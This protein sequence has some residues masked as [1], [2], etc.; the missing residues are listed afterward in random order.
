[1]KYKV[2]DEVK[3][4]R[5]NDLKQE[6]VS[7]DEDGLLV[8]VSEIDQDPETSSIVYFNTSM[9]EHCGKTYI[10]NNVKETPNKN[11][12]YKLENIHTW[13][14]TETMFER[15]KPEV[16]NTIKPKFKFNKD[17]L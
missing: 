2:G 6:A 13:V 14:F 1:M 16:L 12:L 7:E 11:Y 17:I 9:Y 5:L 4:R 8:F 10:I 3:I 15:L